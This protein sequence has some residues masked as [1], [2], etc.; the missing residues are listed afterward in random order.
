MKPVIFLSMSAA[1]VLTDDC[2]ASDK[3]LLVYAPP[4]DLAKIRQHQGVKGAGV[5]ILHVDSKSGAVKSVDVQ[6]S[7]GAAF[8]DQ[9]AIE[10]LQKWPARP[11]TN[12]TVRIPMSFTGRYPW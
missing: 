3:A 1:A 7:T 10:T 12:P 5:L 8:L 2:F 11:G 9:I 4:P 6:K